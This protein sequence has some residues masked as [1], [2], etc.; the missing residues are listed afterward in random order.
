MAAGRP[1]AEA[2]DRPGA[3]PAALLSHALAVRLF[4]SPEAAHGRTLRLQRREV[5]IVGVATPP[6]QGTFGGLAQELWVTRAGWQS[7][8]PEGLGGIQ[9]LGRLAPGASLASARAEMQRLAD[10]LAATDPARAGWQARVHRPH[11][12]QRGFTGGLAPLVGVLLVVVALVLAVACANLASLLLARAVDRQRE[13]A[14]RLALG[15]ERRDLA[16]QQL[17]ESLLLSLLGAAAGLVPAALLA[18]AIF[19]LLPLEGFAVGLDLG[20]DLPVV[21]ATLAVTLVAAIVTALA[22]LWAAAGVAPTTT[23]RAESPG[24]VGGFGKSRLRSTLVVVQLAF[25]LAALAA[26]ALLV[27]ATARDLARDPGFARAGGLVATV[28][29]ASAGLGADDGRRLV[30]GVLA[31]IGALAGVESVSATS[32]VPMGVSGGGNGRRIEIE[33]YVPGPQE[34][35]GV[36]S[37]S[38]AP[39]FFAT[40]GVRLVAGRDVLPTDDAAGTPVVLVTRE[41]ERRYF[42]GE[43]AL[44]RRI[45]VAG[46]WREVVGVVDDATY[47]ALDE[48]KLPRIYLPLAQVWEERLT[49]LVRARGDA[50]RFAGPLRAALAAADPDLPVA[51]VQSLAAHAEGSLFP[52]RIASRLLSA[53]GVLALALAAIGL[54]GLLAYSVTARRRELGVRAALGAPATAI[55]GSVVRDGLRLAAL[56]AAG[57]LLLATGLTRMLASAFPGLPSFDPWSAGIAAVGL[58]ATALLA[59]A[60]PALRAARVSPATVLRED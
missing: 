59:A 29:L 30:D 58:V 33:G 51:G 5:A 4:G 2:D 38:V 42:G 9:L 36:V 25:S 23:L 32:Y 19:R 24:A 20:L 47:R 22:P 54:Y 16:R 17:A 60:V 39:G 6:F 15:A 34:T 13:T 41:L 26:A 10:R 37:D 46:A 28:N 45:R 21:G 52:Y 44:G 57:G 56:G 43:P 3:E 7:L 12:S 49:F 8:V 55:V 48:T 35:M 27:R 18:G 31:R 1:L 11:E 50:T 53:L 14:I 40:L